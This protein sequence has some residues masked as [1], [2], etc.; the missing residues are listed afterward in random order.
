MK[1][2]AHVVMM[3]GAVNKVYASRR[4]S[5][6]SRRTCENAIVLVTKFDCPP[7]DAESAASVLHRRC[8]RRLFSTAIR[9][10]VD[11]DRRSRQWIPAK[12]S[13]VIGKPRRAH[14]HA[15]VGMDATPISSS[16]NLS[17]CPSAMRRAC[18]K[19]QMSTGVSRRCSLHARVTMTGCQMSGAGQ[20]ACRSIPNIE[21]W[22]LQR[23]ASINVPTFRRMSE[24]ALGK[25]ETAEQFE[26]EHRQTGAHVRM[27]NGVPARCSLHAR[28]T[29]AGGQMS[30][31][32]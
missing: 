8:V 24:R 28:V 21:V 10:A 32:G 15:S 19:V 31:A 1:A 16:T 17:A 9:T 26:Q 29:M 6:S 12:P 30:G 5:I 25:P 3:A 23:S 20:D 13:R 4:R 14:P 27:N 7:H 22:H 11:A 2:C 18:V